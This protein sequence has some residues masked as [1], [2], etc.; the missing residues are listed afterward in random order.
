MPLAESCR[1]VDRMRAE[2]ERSAVPVGIAEDRW[3]VVWCQHPWDRAEDLVLS[4]WTEHMDM[5]GGQ[6]NCH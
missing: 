3:A 1:Q 5:K 2:R 4:A 6:V